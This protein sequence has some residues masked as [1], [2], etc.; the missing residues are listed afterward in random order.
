LIPDQDQDDTL[1]QLVPI[2]FGDKILLQ[3]YKSGKYLGLEPDA[4]SL[5]KYRL[6]IQDEASKHTF[7]R[8]QPCYKYQQLLNNPVT[9]NDHFLLRPFED[10]DQEM[11]ILVNEEFQG[12]KQLPEVQISSEKE[13]KF[14]LEAPNHI[15]RYIIEW[16]LERRNIQ[17][18]VFMDTRSSRFVQSNSRR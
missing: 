4:E 17:A 10:F 1:K 16:F 12:T 11:R 6:T 8:L 3:H 7:F 15:S 13:S 18:I 2:R 9:S 14:R 5:G